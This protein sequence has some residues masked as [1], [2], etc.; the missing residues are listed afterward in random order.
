MADHVLASAR[1]FAPVFKPRVYEDE[2]EWRM[3]FFRDS[4]VTDPADGRR[5]I[6][7]PDTPVGAICLGPECP[8]PVED[9]QLALAGAGY[10][11]ASIDQR[12]IEGHF[13]LASRWNALRLTR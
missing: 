11:G 2:N 4:A 1:W 12:L 10:T 9:F 6:E 5:Y 8:Y 3:F 13:P 7:L